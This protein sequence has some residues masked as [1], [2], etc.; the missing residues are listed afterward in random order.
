MFY[1]QMSQYYPDVMHDCL[2]KLVKKCQYTPGVVFFY[3]CSP[4]L[5]FCTRYYAIKYFVD[6]CISFVDLK[7]V[8]FLRF[9]YSSAPT[10]F[11][12]KLCCFSISSSFFT[13]EVRVNAEG[14]G[15]Y[16]ERV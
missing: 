13:F 4:P 10:P 2:I 5:L 11:M 8:L 1:S 12:I 9:K 7:D 14:T 6:M 15:C 3:A 16:L